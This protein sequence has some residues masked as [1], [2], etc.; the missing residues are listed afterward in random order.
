[1]GILACFEKLEELLA[2]NKTKTI[3]VTTVIL[4][5]M[6]LTFIDDLIKCKVGLIKY[7]YE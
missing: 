3:F 2:Q 6:K 5:F 1:M 4:I 7:F